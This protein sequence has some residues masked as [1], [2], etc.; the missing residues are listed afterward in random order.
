MKKKT[1]TEQINDEKTHN[2]MK[3]KNMLKNSQKKQR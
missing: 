1:K 2:L 3:K